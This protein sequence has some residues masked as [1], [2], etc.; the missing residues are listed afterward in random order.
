LAAAGT[1]AFVDHPLLSPPPHRPPCPLPPTREPDNL[2]YESLR[3]NIHAKRYAVAPARPVGQG[4]ASRSSCEEEEEEEG[5]DDDGA[6]WSVKGTKVAKKEAQRRKRRTRGQHAGRGGEEQEGGSSRR[7]QAGEEESE[8]QGDEE[9]QGDADDEEQRALQHDMEA[10][11]LEGRLR[12]LSGAL[13]AASAAAAVAPVV[14]GLVGEPNVGKSSTLN[15]LLGTH[16]VAVS[17]HPGRT[18]HYQ[19]HYVSKQLVLCDCPGLV[20]PRLDVSLPMQVLFGSF[21]IAHCRNPYSV[22]RYLAER[23]WPRVQDSLRLKPPRPDEDAGVGAGGGAGGNGRAAV[24][25]P[26]ANSGGEGFAWSPLTLCEA[27]TGRHNWRSRRGGR[28]DVYR[29]ANWLL[30]GALAGKEGLVLAFL[31][32]DETG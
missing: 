11:T 3:R 32:P 16:R 15:T 23:I 4:A 30:R 9:Q 24:A 17:S 18:K 29:A 25:A 13:Q 20:F 2:T 12:S 21:P 27:L 28:P 1:V 8:E 26:A 22:V 6:G 5:D 31:P 10:L 19:T 14:V 7:T